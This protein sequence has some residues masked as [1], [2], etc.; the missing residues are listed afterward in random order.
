MTD[1]EI[2]AGFH[3]LFDNFPEPVM[4][5]QKSRVMIAVNK[6]AAQFGL[7]PGN[8]CAD[9]GKP[10]Q[11][12]GCRLSIAADTGK[13]VSI[14]YDGPFG[15]AYGYWVPVDGRPDWMLH[16]GVGATFAYEHV[17]TGAQ[18]AIRLVDKHVD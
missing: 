12:E 14:S 5:T 13:P 18:K 3:A 15:R 4:I 10:E 1:E 11:H 9:L 8:R 6:K 7:V 16:F 2:I 17:S